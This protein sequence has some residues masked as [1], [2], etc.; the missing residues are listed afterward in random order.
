MFSLFEDRWVLL[1][2][3]KPSSK[4]SKS[5]VRHRY[6]SQHIQCDLLST[7]HLNNM[8]IRSRGKNSHEFW[9]K[10]RNTIKKK[11]GTSV[12]DLELGVQY[13]VATGSE[14]SWMD[15]MPHV[16]LFE[17]PEKTPSN[18]NWMNHPSMLGFVQ[19][20]GNLESTGWSCCLWTK[21]FWWYKP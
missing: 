12:K 6:F 11:T 4:I 17:T 2:E 5:N 7:S 10:S 13:L 9:V 20:W 1:P 16:C 19:K 18:L 21:P 14:C 15:L 8:Q 3:I